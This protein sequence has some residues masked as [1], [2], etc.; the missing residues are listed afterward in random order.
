MI[1]LLAQKPNIY[2][3]SLK[4]RTSEICTNEILIKRGYPVYLITNIPLTLVEV[5]M[6]LL[7]ELIRAALTEFLGLSTFKIM[8]IVPCRS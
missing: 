7:K 4:N 6:E 5:V 2:L 3:V 1:K 8:N